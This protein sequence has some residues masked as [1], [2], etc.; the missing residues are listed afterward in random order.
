MKEDVLVIGGGPGGAA[1]A[2]QLIENGFHPVIIEAITF[3]RFHIGESLT[4]EC[5]DALNRMGLEQRLQALAPPRKRGV[6]IFSGNPN[7]SFY[8]G[9]GDAWQV[10]RAG[11]DEMM[12]DEARKR[13]ATH[14]QGMV[15]SIQR[16]DDGWQL[17]VTTDAGEISMTARFVIDAS[18]QKRFCQRQGLFG[19]LIEGDYARQ[20]A[21][22]SQFEGVAH[23]ASDGHDT[24]I[25]HRNHQEWVWMI[26]LSESVTSIG[27]VT[28][29]SEFR[30]S[31][32]PMEA[33]LEQNLASFSEPLTQRLH[34][35][36]RRGSVA[37]ASN[38]S[39]AI[40]PY[41]LDG[42]FCVGDSHRFIDPI[43]SFG[44]QFAV[45]EAG[46]AADAIAECASMPLADWQGPQ[47]CYM[48]V[49][50]DAQNVISDMLAYFWAHPWGFA[51]M[52]HQR[53]PDEFLEMFA[54]RIYE[55][56]PGEG[57]IKMRKA[58]A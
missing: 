9:A 2:M 6:R 56:Q 24:L 42:L 30:N 54:G 27:L 57:L 53:Y 13:G 18:G 1:S 35:I 37:A 3:P 25:F 12:L 44:V 34:S 23:G 43:F 38:Y 33:Y 17:A 45:V 4:T 7:N 48:T 19:E 47:Q 32:L 10:E 26:P 52:A 49:T 40:E 39:F 51:N 22:F 58:M 14:I 31:G 46:Y 36:K 20:I 8:V 15:A 55:R 50:T 29:V 16:C 28:P 41:C 11:F 21:M 5:V